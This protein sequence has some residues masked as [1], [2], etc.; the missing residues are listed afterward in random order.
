MI[1]ILHWLFS[2]SVSP[3]LAFKGGTLAYFCYDL[4]RYS[5]DIDLDLLDHSY[6]QAVMDEITSLLSR[7]GDIK[8]TTLGADLHRWIFR[9]DLQSTNIKVELNKRDLTHNQYEI[10]PIHGMDI[11]CMDTSSM[12]S[13]KLLALGDRRY[14]RDLY[15]TYFFRV[16]GYE[17]DERIIQARSGKTVRELIT[18]IIKELPDHY[19]E[20]TILADG[21]GDV[22]TDTQKSRVK[23]HLVPETTKLLQLYLD[24]H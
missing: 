12:V 24:T 14:N 7:L 5:T 4:D 9:Y 18:H 1:K 2:S 21:M 6:E 20:N 23:T 15:D 16:Q 10:R 22:L 17:Y 13:N 3:Y 11:H 8:N 19:A